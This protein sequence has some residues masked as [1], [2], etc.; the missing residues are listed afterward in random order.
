MKIAGS[1]LNPSLLC[2]HGL[3]GNKEEWDFLFNALSSQFFCIAIDLPGHGEA[4][5][6]EEDAYT[7]ASVSKSIISVL[8]KLEISSTTILGYSMGGRV[9]LYTSFQYPSYF[10]GVILSSSSPGL[11]SLPER[12]E[13]YQQDLILAECLEKEEFADFLEEWYQQPLFASLAA[14]PNILNEVKQKRLK[15]SP[16][17]I[18]KAVRGFGLGSQPSLWEKITSLN[19]PLSIFV[20]AHDAKYQATGQLMLSVAPQAHM[21]VIPEAGHNIHDENPVEFISQIKKILTTKSTK[22]TKKTIVK[23]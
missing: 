15:N 7:W 14:K 13:R 2:I 12:K 16:H 11:N 1:S 17:H 20:G 21:W 4:L 19:M 8:N 9:A 3:F 23:N 18:A 10:N 22:S 6:N 5:F